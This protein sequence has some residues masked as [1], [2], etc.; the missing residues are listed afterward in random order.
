VL[1]WKWKRLKEFSFLYIECIKNP[2]MY[3][4]WE[5]WDMYWENSK[6][7]VKTFYTSFIKSKNQFLD[8]TS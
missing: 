1:T 2:G 4:Y 6:Y 7:E 8:Y 5:Y 3:L